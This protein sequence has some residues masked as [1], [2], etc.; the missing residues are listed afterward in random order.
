MSHAV[1]AMMSI[2]PEELE[3]FK[4]KLWNPFSIKL[5]KRVLMLTSQSTKKM[6]YNLRKS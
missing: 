4:K 2:I 5:C 1:A 6:I 3:F